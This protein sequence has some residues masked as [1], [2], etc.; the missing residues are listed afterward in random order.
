MA[1]ARLEIKG[2][3]GLCTFHFFANFKPKVSKDHNPLK[4]KLGL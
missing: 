3:G 1:W 4:P 2:E